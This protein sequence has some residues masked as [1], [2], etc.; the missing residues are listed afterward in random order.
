MI[1]SFVLLSAL[2][3]DCVDDIKCLR[4]DAGLAG[5][6]GYRPSAPETARQWLDGFHN[7][8]LMMAQPLQGIFI[9]P[10]SKSVVGLKEI[11]RRAIWAYVENLKPGQ[12]VTL[13]VDAQL[14]ETSKADARYCYEGYKAYQLLQVSWAETLLAL[15]D[16]FRD[17]NVPAGK[18]IEVRT[19][20]GHAT[21]LSDRPNHR[22]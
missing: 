15:A 12:E 7:E 3:G 20:Q 18:D 11:S 8:A 21:D 1:E 9:P 13:G 16:E 2:G 4:D 10:E 5:I 22:S 19:C 17:G 6:L 14:I